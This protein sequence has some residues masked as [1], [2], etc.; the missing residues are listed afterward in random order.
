[1]FFV[2]FWTTCRREGLISITISYH[3]DTTVT[4]RVQ[5]KQLASTIATLLF[6]FLII[7]PSLSSSEYP[8][9]TASVSTFG[10]V[11]NA[12]RTPS[13]ENSTSLP[14]IEVSGNKIQYLNGTQVWLRGVDIP[15]MDWSPARHDKMTL[16][17]F[18]YMRQWGVNVVR[19]VINR[20]LWVAFDDEAQNLARLDD[21]VLTWTEAKGIYAVI[22]YH[23]GSVDADSGSEWSTMEGWSGWKT[24][25]TNMATRYNGTTH[26]MYDLMNEPQNISPQLYQTKMRDAIDT[27]RAIDPNDPVIILEE[28]SENTW[29][30]IALNYE[31]THPISR[32]N[33]IFSPHNFFW[34]TARGTSKTS[35]RSRLANDGAKWC[36]DNGRAVWTGEFNWDM[37]FTGQDY[38]DGETWFRNYAE[39]MDEDGY[40][41]YASWG[42][43]T[44]VEHDKYF[45]L[46]DWNGNPSDMGSIL[47]EYLAHA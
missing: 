27:I 32:S 1:M 13:Q 9:P 19:I 30:D 46:A 26:V 41:G 43:Q 12:P 4:G 42:W 15:Y 17:Q 18:E 3:Y 36:I 31:K 39:V 35:I 6:C 37:R 7:A 28:I 23:W 47:Q 38:Q 44:T 34:N 16:Q 25:W 21:M 11:A 24:F 10:E 40:S 33:V 8:I 29:G 2:Y 5:M 14:R 20:H 22:S 45:L